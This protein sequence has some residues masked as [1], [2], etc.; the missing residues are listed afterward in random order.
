MSELLDFLF[1]ADRNDVLFAITWLVVLVLVATVASL[2]R[3][4]DRVVKV[5]KNRGVL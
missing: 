3:H 5:L 1:A 2:H 4:L